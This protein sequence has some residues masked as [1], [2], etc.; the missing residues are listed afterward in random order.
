MASAP[1]VGDMWN[2]S[3]IYNAALYCIFFNSL[4]D[5][6]KDTPLKY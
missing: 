5:L 4:K 6:Y 2:A 1:Q 3:V